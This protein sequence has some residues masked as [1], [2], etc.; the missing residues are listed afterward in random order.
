MKLRALIVQM[1]GGI[2]EDMYRRVVMNVSIRVLEYATQ[3]VTLS[4]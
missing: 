1:C 4:M 2:T 3:V